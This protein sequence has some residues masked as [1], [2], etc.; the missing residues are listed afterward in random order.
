V[1]KTD[2]IGALP[3]GSPMTDLPS[4]FTWYKHIG[5]FLTNGAANIK[6]FL[7]VGNC[8]HWTETIAN[9]YALTN[10]GTNRVLAALYGPPSTQCLVS[11]SIHRNTA[12][13]TY[14]F[15][16]SPA[17]TNTTPTSVGRLYD[18]HGYASRME[19]V[20]IHKEVVLDSSSRVAYRFSVSDADTHISLRVVYWID[21]KI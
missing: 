12:S 17:V 13:A 4:G 21:D 2:D 6:P 18:V 8:F 3:V 20:N 5:Y 16:C 11:A 19:Q 14:V 15:M 9:E 7:Q 10:P 1:G